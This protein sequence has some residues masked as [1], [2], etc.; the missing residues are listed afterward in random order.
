MLYLVM[1][2]S[3]KNGRADQIGRP[4]GRTTQKCTD[5]GRMPPLLVAQADK[6]WT[7]SMSI[8]VRTLKLA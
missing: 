2:N 5:K 6:R 4:I 3:T 8:L 7:K 1:E